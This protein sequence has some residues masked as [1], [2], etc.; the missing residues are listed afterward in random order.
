M[1]CQ[2]PANNLIELNSN[3][4]IK[5]FHYSMERSSI[6]CNST[7]DVKYTVKFNEEGEII[8]ISSPGDCDDRFYQN[9]VQITNE[10]LRFASYQEKKNFW[11]LKGVCDLTCR[12]TIQTS[13]RDLKVHTP[14]QFKNNTLPNHVKEIA[15]KTF[16][17]IS[18]FYQKNPKVL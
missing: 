18:Q 16:E 8:G 4:F 12:I 2:L 13:F 9:G 1:S 6:M 11:H 15:D 10:S 17:K 14:L 5:D 3:L 7:Y